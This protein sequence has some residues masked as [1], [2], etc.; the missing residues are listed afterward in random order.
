MFVR[1]R[2]TQVVQS[3]RDLWL[4]LLDGVVSLLHLRKILLAIAGNPRTMSYT[5]VK[6]VFFL[7]IPGNSSRKVHISLALLPLAGAE[8]PL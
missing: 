2:Q 8:V 5:W 4:A 7:C 1:V 3:D 6:S